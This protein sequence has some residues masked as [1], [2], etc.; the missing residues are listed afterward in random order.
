MAKIHPTAVVSKEAELADS[1]EVGP[2][3]VI[4]PHVK[5][6]EGTRVASHVMIDGY[7]EIG[8]RCQIYPMACL[9]M[10]PQDKLVKNERPAVMI[11]DDNIIRE[12]VTIHCSTDQGAKTVIGNKNYLMATCHVAHD[13]VLGNEIVIANYVGLSGH[14]VIEDKA[15]IGGMSGIHQRSRV[16]KL[17]MVGGVSK[18]TRDVPPFSLCDGN[19]ARFFGINVVGLRRAGYSAAAIQDIRKALKILCA[20]GVKLAAAMKS[21]RDEVGDSNPEITHLLKFVEES[22]RSIARTTADTDEEETRVFENR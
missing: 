6:D 15:V 19:P 3:T 12:Q 13:C 8:K 2:Y 7:T 22:E 11:G 16:G 5:I 14:V 10:S 17:A 20:S 18:V 9:G 4:G 21:V 1:V